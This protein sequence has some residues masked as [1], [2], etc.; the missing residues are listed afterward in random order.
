V[1]EWH[2]FLVLL[3]I[4]AGVVVIYLAIMAVILRLLDGKWFRFYD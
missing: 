2:A 1:S 4:T 3:A